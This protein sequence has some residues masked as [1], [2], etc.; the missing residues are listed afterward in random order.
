MDPD[1]TDS[2]VQ[3]DYAEV[4]LI[5]PVVARLAVFARRSSAAQI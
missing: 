4:L 5:A 3:A 2:V 1:M